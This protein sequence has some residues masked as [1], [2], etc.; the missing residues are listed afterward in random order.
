MEVWLG[1]ESLEHGDQS[2]RGLWCDTHRVKVRLA[3]PGPA[4]WCAGP[5]LCGPS[6]QKMD[7]KEKLLLIRTPLHISYKYFSDFS[8]RVNNIMV[9]SARTNKGN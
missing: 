3:S 8:Y 5:S 6:L 2:P 4:E 7:L 1:Q 9:M